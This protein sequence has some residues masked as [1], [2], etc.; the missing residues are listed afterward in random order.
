MKL[1]TTPLAGLHEIRTTPICDAR[2]RFTRLYCEQELTAIRPGLH[3]TQIN[4]SETRGLGTLRGLHYQKAP[5]AEAKFIRCLR[6]RVFDVAVDLRTDSP[7][8]LHWHAMELAEDNDRAVFIPEGFAHGFQTLTDEAQLLYM[9]T[10]PWT[11]AC[12]GGLRHD[13]PRLAIA[14]P[15]AVT[16]TSDRDRSYA[17][18]SSEFAGVSA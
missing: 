4:L 14:W 3:F 18:I 15:L 1:L 17:L 13:D 5:A 12:E 11:P 16:T 2:G 8:F 10:A 6:G 9:H 7:T